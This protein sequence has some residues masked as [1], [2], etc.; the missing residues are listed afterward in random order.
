MTPDAVGGPGALPPGPVGSAVPS[1][2]APASSGHFAEVLDQV[3]FSHHAE[4]RMRQRH[5]E[6][7]RQDVLLLNRA[8]EQA[9][10]SGAQRA[11]V[12]MPQGI[13]IVAPPTHTV[14]TSIERTNNGAMQVI[15][16]VDALVLVDRTEQ[17]VS[18][19]RTTEGSPSTPPHWSLVDPGE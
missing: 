3:R 17:E 10:K 18:R 13:F 8:M 7:S 1:A 15:S 2:P 4:Q 11:A 16:Q 19:S 14:I 9:G 5:L 12:V 6:L